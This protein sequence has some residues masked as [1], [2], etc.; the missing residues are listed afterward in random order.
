MNYYVAGQQ[1]YAAVGMGTN[2][3]VTVWES[4]GQDGSGYGVFGRVGPLVGSGDFDGDG[5]VGFGDYCFLAEQWRLSG[6]GLVADVIDDGVVN[7]LDLRGFFGQWLDYDCECGQSD[8]DG[9]GVVNLKDYSV[10]AGQ[11]TEQGLGLDSDVTGDGVV[12]LA[13]LGMLGIW[14]T[15]GCE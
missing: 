15:M 6:D 10:W 5:F 12:G 1:R 13:D 11:F 7:E 2:G 14:W 8:L 3:F 4:Y 9:D